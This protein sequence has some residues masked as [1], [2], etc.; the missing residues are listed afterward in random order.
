MLA[1][2]V[3]LS[4]VGCG[5]FDGG[6]KKKSHKDEEEDEEEETTIEET[7][8][9]EETTQ[10]E[11]SVRVTPDQT[12]ASTYADVE[13]PNPNY[14][15]VMEL[16]TD[17]N[18]VTG[19]MIL[20]FTNTSAVDLNEIYLRDY[21]AAFQD[22][23]GTY[24]MDISGVQDL[25]SGTDVECERDGDDMTTVIIPLDEPLASGEEISLYM[26]FVTTLPT[27]GDRF[28]YYEGVYSLTDF[29]PILCRFDMDGNWSHEPYF[30]GGECFYTDMSD[31]E[32]ELTVPEGYMVGTG[33]QIISEETDGG[34]TSYEITAEDIRDFTAIASDE[35][36][37]IEAEQNGVQ[38]YLYYVPNDD[39][40]AEAA[41]A[42]MD[43][44]INSIEYFSECFGDYPY[45]TL[46]CVF[47][48]MPSSVGG[49][50]YSGLVL[51]SNSMYF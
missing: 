24:E 22:K 11:P 36:V 42:Y 6:H 9:S 17:N 38:Y 26:D 5:L 1:A 51:I 13:N 34:Y 41:E 31:F 15:M 40:D 37:E 25:R 32:V 23:N 48:T 29:Y 20:T 10:S 49:M 35:F 33:G 18:T 43:V 28:G 44:C 19:S 39:L 47:S 21:P 8:A 16:D 3:L 50:E 27:I 30:F 46:T 14:E 12:S 4:F 7:E 45:P 2:A